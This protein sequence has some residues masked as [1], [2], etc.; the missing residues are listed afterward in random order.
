MNLISEHGNADKEK[1]MAANFHE[2][3]TTDRSLRDAMRKI[4]AHARAPQ[5]SPER[6]TK[7]ELMAQIDILDEAERDHEWTVYYP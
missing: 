6:M 5:G 3:H 7:E 1:Q 4:V 2:S